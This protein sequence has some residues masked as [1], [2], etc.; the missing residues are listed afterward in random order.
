MPKIEKT[1]ML[2]DKENTYLMLIS[3][4]IDQIMKEKEAFVLK[5]KMEK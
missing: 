5:I 2:I 4:T 3:T 1:I